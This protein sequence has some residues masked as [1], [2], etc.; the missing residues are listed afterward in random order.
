MFE[1]AIH[2][3]QIYIWD[4]GLASMLFEYFIGQ[5]AHFLMIFLINRMNINIKSF[6]YTEVHY[7]FVISYIW[8]FEWD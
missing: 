5:F 2:V 1:L 4:S 6:P 3:S 8:L 7:N